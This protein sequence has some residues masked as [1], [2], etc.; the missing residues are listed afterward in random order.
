M[1]FRIFGRRYS[2]R[3][4]NKYRKAFL[5]NQKGVHL[6]V[7]DV[8]PLQKMINEGKLMRLLPPGDPEF[9]VFYKGG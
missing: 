4:M 1:K 9:K 6:L 3:K 8:T 5:K 2:F 7:C